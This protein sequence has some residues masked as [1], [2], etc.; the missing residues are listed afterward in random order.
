MCYAIPGK[1][2]AIEG[3]VITVNYFGEQ[4]KAYNELDGLKVGDYVYAQGGYAIQKLDTEDAESILSVWK[5][6]FFELQELDLRLS[7]MDLE[8]KDIDP[9]TT[10]IL[11]KINHGKE[12]KKQDLSYLISLD[13]SSEVGLVL[14]NAN[15]LRQKYHKNACCVHGI[16]EIANVCN[17]A[18]QYCG[19]STYVDGLSRYKMT[20]D[21][22]YEAAYEAVEKYGFKALVL[23]S[24]E[25][26]GYDIDVLAGIVKRIRDELGALIFISFGELDDDSLRKFYEAGA[27]GILLRFETSNPELYRKVHPG[28]ELDS[29]VECL[30]KAYDMGY[31]IITGALVGLSGQTDEDIVNDII[32]A[33]DLKTEMYSFGPF[34]PVP[35]TPLEDQHPINTDKMLK[36]LALAR[37]ADPENG[38]VLVTTAFETLSSDARKRGLMAGA[39][40]VMLNATPIKYRKLYSI[41]PARAHSDEEISNQIEETLALL[42]SLGRSP[43]DLGATINRK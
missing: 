18:C 5:E 25:D 27:R 31:L 24:G 14:K 26:C 34:L 43:T 20:I 16:I 7:K 13:K 42:R 32:L 15:F 12:L 41:Y 37:F 23:Q 22:I 36:S 8:S 29:R 28:Q 2:D 9:K 38:K 40:S 3:K 39:S 35:G 11:D 6:T 21:E 1:V 10:R 33:K 17:R 4:K 19:I 30:R